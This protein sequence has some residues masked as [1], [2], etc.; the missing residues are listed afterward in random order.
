MQRMP[1]QSTSLAVIDDPL[2]YVPK[3]A[4]RDPDAIEL[5]VIHC[6]ELPDLATARQYGERVLYPDG[7]GASGHYYVDRDGSVHRYVPNERVAQHVR[8]RNAGSIGIE[9]VNLGR[10]PDWFRTDRQAMTEPY[11][12]AQVWALIR[13]LERLK[14]EL[15][16]LRHIAGHE[17]L[18]RETVVA[19]DD[20][21][22]S[23]QR[24]LD[25]GPQFPWDRVLGV[26]PLER[27]FA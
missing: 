11:T 27:I 20:P 3:L 17:D 18:D 6:T 8:G 24:K 15:P 21:T 14:A 10:F 9:L 7:T 23:V 12:D 2:P 4:L 22:R 25:P 16:G 26:T 1:F 5:V 13:L 19:T